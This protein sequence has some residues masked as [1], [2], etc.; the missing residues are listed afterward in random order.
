M[1]TITIEENVETEE[2]LE[3]INLKIVEK[4]LRFAL[5]E[6]KKS[7]DVFQRRKSIE[8]I[9]KYYDLFLIL[10]ICMPTH[11]HRIE[12]YFS[13]GLHGIFFI[14]E[15]AKKIDCY[16]DTLQSAVDLFPKGLVFAQIDED[17]ELIQYLINLKVIPVVFNKEEAYLFHNSEDWMK[18]TRLF[19]NEGLENGIYDKIKM[20][21]MLEK[22]NL[23]QK[24]MVKQ[25]DQSLDS[26]GL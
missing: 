3:Q 16:K 21:F 20:K 23:R 5:V 22:V 14:Q 4:D 13:Y 8:E 7:M 18:Y 24:L 25:M 6:F 2:L 15:E 12:E 9:K 17:K 26:S 1:T 19:G 11:P 10:K